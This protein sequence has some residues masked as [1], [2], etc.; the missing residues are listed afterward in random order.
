VDYPQMAPGSAFGMSVAVA[1]TGGNVS[2]ATATST[3]PEGR[4]R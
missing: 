2:Q 4:T 1:D 3:V